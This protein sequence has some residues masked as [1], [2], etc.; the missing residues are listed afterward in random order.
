MPSTT[1]IGDRLRCCAQCPLRSGSTCAGRLLIDRARPALWDCPLVSASVGDAA[2]VAAPAPGPSQP[3]TPVDW[4]L[5]DLRRRVTCA[6][7]IPCHNYGR[8]LGDAIESVLAQSL[9][10]REILIVDDASTDDTPAVAAT[11]AARGVR[12]LR[13]AHRNV[14]EARKAGLA[15]TASDLV[16]F[17]DADDCL[18]Q[19]YLEHAARILAA[20]WRIAIAHSDLDRFG[21]ETGR[22]SFAALLT[23]QEIERD[24]QI[25]AGAVVRREALEVSRAFEAAGDGI[26]HDD[27]LLWRRVLRHGYRAQKSPACYR[28]RR[29]AGGHRSMLAAA[30]GQPW[31]LQCRV[32]LE[33]VSLAIPL[34]GRRWAWERLAAFL[35]RQTWPHDQIRLVLGD[36]SQD[37][38]FAAEVRDWL[39]RCDYPDARRIE[40]APARPGLADESRVGRRD[41]QIDVER[42]MLRIWRR[43]TA[44]LDTPW[45]WLIEDD[46]LPPDDALARL[47]AHVRP[48]VDAIASPYVGRHQREQRHWVVFRGRQPVPHEQPGRGVERVEGAGCGCVVVRTPLLTSH[49]WD[50]P[51]GTWYD[52]AFFAGKHVLADW[53]TISEHGPPIAESHRRAG[54]PSTPSRVSG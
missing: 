32:D 50:R 30:Q 18:G 40:F 48:Q 1:L 19:D 26:S 6:V 46:V 41:V 5:A 39:S 53:S 22:T 28:Y 12:Y 44:G 16:C 7:V 17:L 51:Q 36:T 54:L 27:W 47:L 49:V 11:F 29:H 21:A 34:S 35:E 42:A 37:P 52:P 25:H 20:D 13:V 3:S 4:P 38:A 14:W 8:F 2:S 31:A 43:L 33:T 45:T 15:A 23:A 24:N 9:P 10:A